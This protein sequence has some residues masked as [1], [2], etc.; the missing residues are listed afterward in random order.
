M[1]VVLCFSLLR[2]SIAAAAATADDVVA[3]KTVTK[4]DGGP[5]F[6]LASISIATAGTTASSS[7]SGGVDDDCDFWRRMDQY[8]NDTYDN[9]CVGPRVWCVNEIAATTVTTATNYTPNAA[10]ARR[11][12]QTAPSAAA[13]RRRT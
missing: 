2:L 13:R 3:C 10:A 5:L 1:I 9:G 8:G 6:A 4:N 11:S 12:L 7:S